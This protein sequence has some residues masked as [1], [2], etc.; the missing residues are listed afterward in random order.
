MTPSEG[1]AHEV[2]LAIADRQRPGVFGPVVSA[3]PDIEQELECLDPVAA[4][5]C[6]PVPLGLGDEDATEPISYVAE[7]SVPIEGEQRGGS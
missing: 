4:A 1:R 7:M 5:V 2:T 6:S 3:V